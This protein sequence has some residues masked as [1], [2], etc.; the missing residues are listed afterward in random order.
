MGGRE[1][2][3]LQENFFN[4][5]LLRDS[6]SHPSD[7]LKTEF[8]SRAEGVDMVFDPVLTNR[9]L[10]REPFTHGSDLLSL[11]IMVSHDK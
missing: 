4:G 3:L 6:D 5:I 10:A 1:P 9:L 11:N 7:I 2:F 8:T